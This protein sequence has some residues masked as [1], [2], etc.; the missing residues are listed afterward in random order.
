MRKLYIEEYDLIHRLTRSG[1]ISFVISTGKEEKAL[2][3]KNRILYIIKHNS[4]FLYV[5]EA[6]SSLKTKLERGF[7]SYRFYKRNGKARN[8]YKGYKWI[9]LFENPKNKLNIFV[10]LFNK[11]Y[12]SNEGRKI[13]EAIEGELVYLIRSQLG[14]WPKF[15]NGI[16]F[17]N[18]NFA[19]AYAK[20]IYNEI[21]I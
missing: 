9:E 12:S 14:Y 3:T 5:G 10:V 1:E 17:N 20:N 18:N 13:I 19:V 6:K 2:N 8:G 4:K 16:H 15:Q 11:S 21:N 7:S